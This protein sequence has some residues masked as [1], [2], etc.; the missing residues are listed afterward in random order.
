MVI[1]DITT[2]HHRHINRK[3]SKLDMPPIGFQLIRLDTACCYGET[4]AFTRSSVG[5]SSYADPRSS[6][7]NLSPQQQFAL[8]VV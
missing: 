4:A 5:N 6:C 3:T 1:R 7:D 8:R 2:A